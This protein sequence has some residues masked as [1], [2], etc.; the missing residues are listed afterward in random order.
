MASQRKLPGPP[1][2]TLASERVI[3]S[4]PMSYASATQRIWRALE[5]VGRHIPSPAPFQNCAVRTGLIILGLFLRASLFLIG[6][7]VNLVMVAV[8]TVWCGIFGLLLVPY[9]LLRRGNRK[10]KVGALRHRE[11]LDAIEASRK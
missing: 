5:T 9:R 1:A 6:V 3:L 10:R 8:I 2:G 4:A 7:V 11:R